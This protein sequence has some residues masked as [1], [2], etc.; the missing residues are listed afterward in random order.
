MGSGWGT[1]VG[2]SYPLTFKAALKATEAAAGTFMVPWARY[3]D[4][5]LKT[6]LRN[7]GQITTQAAHR[8]PYTAKCFPPRLREGVAAV[9][10]REGRV[11]A[12]WRWLVSLRAL[13]LKE[14]LPRLSI[15]IPGPRTL[16]RRRM[17][18]LVGF[19]AFALYSRHPVD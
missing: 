16:L 9:S 13:T 19:E 15:R 18:L 3:V 4:Q 7:K 10:F 11:E 1:V 5:P 6:T 14:G 8:P 17:E 12:A 2:E